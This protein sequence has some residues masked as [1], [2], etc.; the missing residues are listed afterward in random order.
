MYFQYFGKKRVDE[1]GWRALHRED[2]AKYRV[3]VHHQKLKSRHV[4]TKESREPEILLEREE[5]VLEKRLPED[6]PKQ[7]YADAQDKLV[8][9]IKVKKP[10]PSAPHKQLKTGCVLV[11]YSSEDSEKEP[12]E[13]AHPPEA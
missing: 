8:A 13:G 11:D 6:A 1:E 3:P 10:D 9:K 5:V 12:A 7:A 4:H 2:A